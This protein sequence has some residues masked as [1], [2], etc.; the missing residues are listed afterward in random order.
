MKNPK[1]KRM[2]WKKSKFAKILA[3]YVIEIYQTLEDSK[4]TRGIMFDERPL[5]QILIEETSKEIIG[6]NQAFIQRQ[7]IR[8]NSLLNKKEKNNNNEERN[9]KL[10][11]LSLLKFKGFIRYMTFQG[12]S[13]QDIRYSSCYLKHNFYREGSYVMR[14]YDKS[15]ALYGI[16]TGKVVVRDICPNDKYKK[17]YMDTIRGNFNDE[18]IR[19]INNID[20]EYFMSDLEE[21]SEI[22]DNSNRKT[23]DNNIDNDN[24]NDSVYKN[25]INYK[26]KEKKKKIRR[27]GRGSTVNMRPKYDISIFQKKKTYEIDEKELKRREKLDKLREKF[28]SKLT[29]EQI[30]DL[31]DEKYYTTKRKSIT[32]ISIIKR[33]REENDEKKKKEKKIIKAIKENQ[34]PKDI[35]KNIITL[36]QFI[37]DFEEERVILNQG[38]CFGEWGCVYNIPRTS[39]IYCL[40]DTNLFYLEKKYFDKI[41]YPKF[42][43]A[44]IKKVH[45]ILSKFPFLKKDLKFRHLL[46]KITPEFFDSGDIVYTPFDDAKII[47]LLYRGEASLVELPYKPKNKEDYLNRK[48]DL[49]NIIDFCQGGI[50]G[51]EASQRKGKYD[52]CLIVKKDFTVFLKMNVDYISKKYL[53][54]KESIKDLYEQ[55]KNVIE[56]FE[57]RK[58]QYFKSNHLKEKKINDKK[59]EFNLEMKRPSSAR[60]KST[61]TNLKT[62]LNLS[63]NLNDKSFLFKFDKNSIK[64]R[65]KSSKRPISLKL[66]FNKGKSKIRKNKKHYSNLNTN[67]LTQRLFLTSTTNNNSIINN[68]TIKNSFI[69]TTLNDNDNENEVMPLIKNDKVDK[70]KEILIEHKINKFNLFKQLGLPL[71]IKNYRIKKGQKFFNTGKYEIP[72]LSKVEL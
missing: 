16:I 59:K 7:N 3:N 66:D 26:R 1:K 38:M 62:K 57:E 25:I 31:I 40:E 63:N 2:N 10:I 19:N 58:K 46:T 44:D 64:T 5:A 33:M 45:F 28:L 36:R 60:P 42:S 11:Y 17:F 68:S 50:S 4:F 24:D 20:Y 32:K 61:I 70:K 37:L 34:V 30:D 9:V 6:H 56:K 21:E 65:I 55:H 35:D 53:T 29:E 67:S 23:V 49:K 71:P 51:L 43:A 69:K 18:E 8:R 15:N 12:I 13:T 41:L 14:K 27:P 22:E 47:Y 52:Y 48:S 72:I 39:S 54:F